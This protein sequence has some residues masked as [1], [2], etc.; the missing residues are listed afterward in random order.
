MLSSTIKACFLGLAL[1]LGAIA[2]PQRV[3]AA[4][5]NSRS[6]N[7]QRARRHFLAGKRAFEA[8]RY[9]VALK[10][11]ETGYAIDPRPGF[12][13]NMGH[14]ARRRGELRRA[15]DYYL[16]F[17]ESDPPGAERRTTIGLVMEI[18]RQLA[19][20][21]TA[22]SHASAAP[23]PAAATITHVAARGSGTRGHVKL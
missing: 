7:T 21:S 15:R 16:K 10:E 23:G 19:A 20:A 3:D 5:H 17:L 14:A 8:K 18:D 2:A 11:F 9:P 13:L 22:G 6:V 1:A 12:L 4:P